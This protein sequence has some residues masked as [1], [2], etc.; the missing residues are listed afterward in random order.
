MIKVAFIL[1]FKKNNWLG[2]YN[3]VKNLIL[4]IN[5]FFPKEVK[6]A[7][8]VDHKYNLKDLKDFKKL[9]NTQ[10]IENDLFTNTN[11]FKRNFFKFLSIL[12]GKNIFYEN[13]LIKNQINF[14]SHINIYS[15]SF[16]IG[17]KSF[18]KSITLIPDFQ[19]FYFKK[20]FSMKKVFFRN[21]NIYLS[22]L[23]SN[24]ILL[25]SKDAKKDLLNF[26]HCTKKKIQVIEPSFDPHDHKSVLTLKQLKKKYEI[27]T[28]FFYLPNHYWKHKNHNLVLKALQFLKLKN[29]LKNIFIIST[30]NKNEN[31]D[32]KVFNDVQKFIKKNDLV[33]NY[34]YLGVVE[35]K[36]VMSLM[37]HSTAVINPSEFEGRSSTVEQGDLIGKK[38]LLS[39]IKIHKEQNPSR[40]YYFDTHDFKALAKSIYYLDKSFKRKNEILISKRKIQLGKLKFKLYIKKYIS[41][42]KSI[43]N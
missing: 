42:L 41:F 7:I 13:F 2:G 18:S 38:I 16:I 22:I 17:K 36:D 12:F 39:N 21:L 33:N 40:A 35:Y 34:K 37:L 19:H 14:V 30:G 8:V 15:K 3:L 28:N 25:I 31:Q 4:G 20:N 11:F 23:F 43:K 9:K 24:K 1:N 10:I 5:K 27:N 26:F 29:K 6:I 32:K